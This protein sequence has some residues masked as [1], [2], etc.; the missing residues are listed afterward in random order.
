VYRTSFEKI[1]LQDQKNMKTT[2]DSVEEI[3]RRSFLRTAA[4]I[5]GTAAISPAFTED[6]PAES[7]RLE[8][9]S[10]AGTEARYLGNRLFVTFAAAPE[11][12]GMLRMPRLVGVVQSVRWLEGSSAELAVQPEPREWIIRFSGVPAVPNACLVLTLDLPVQLFRAGQPVA[13]SD[14]TVFLRACQ[15]EVHGKNLRYE[16]QPHKN[17]V[18]YWSVTEDYADWHCEVPADGMYE[19]DIL[20]GC[21][22]GH[23]GSSVEVRVQNQP[24]PLTV[25]ETGHFQNFIWKSLGT[26]ALTKSADSVI[27]V[28]CLKKQAGAVMDVR[29]VRL[30]PVGRPRSLQP[31]LAAPDQLPEGLRG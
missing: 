6:I 18:G 14:G 2:S 4:A 21:G 29:A 1:A 31:E 3:N 10:V 23:G 5:V 15:A 17:T 27:S 25:V 28:R 12:N 8:G 9:W 19:V 22:S 20:Q 13:A 11:A 30:T 7:K 16:P 24:L 26:L